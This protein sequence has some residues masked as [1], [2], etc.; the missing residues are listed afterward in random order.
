M[1]QLRFDFVLL[2]KVFV[3]LI[4]NNYFSDHGSYCSLQQEIHRARNEVMFEKIAN[5]EYRLENANLKV[6]HLGNRKR[7]LENDLNKLQDTLQE[8]KNQFSDAAFLDIMS[9]SYNLP[10]KVFEC[11]SQ[12]VRLCDSDTGSSSFRPKKSYAD[13]IK[14]FCLTLFSYSRK[15]YEFVR[16]EF[17]NC[18]PCVSTIKYWL[19][20][21]DGSAGFSEMALNQIKFKVQDKEKHGEK[22]LKSNLHDQDIKLS[23]DLKKH[24][25]FVTSNISIYR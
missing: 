22:V 25:T 20:K 10:A 5:L 7:K 16:D 18:L 13:D 14:T 24:F 15:A 11:F 3:Y 4:E 8:H 2:D 19:N 12:K 21:V 9:K 6:K 1:G 17:E 23:I